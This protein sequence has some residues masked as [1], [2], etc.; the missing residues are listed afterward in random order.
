MAHRESPAIVCLVA[1]G[2]LR[3][4]FKLPGNHFRGGFCYLL[5][6]S[7]GKL[8]RLERPKRFYHGPQLLI[9]LLLVWPDRRDSDRNYI[10]SISFTKNGACDNNYTERQAAFT[11]RLDE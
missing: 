4:R 10:V 3:G 5:G 1:N 6:Q 2:T 8:F 9:N 11:L 7:Q